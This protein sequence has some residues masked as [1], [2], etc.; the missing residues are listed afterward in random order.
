MHAFGTSPVRFADSVKSCVK[1]GVYRV[2]NPW[3]V[4]LPLM[5]RSR[6]R[7]NPSRP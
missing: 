3:N 6:T 1:R 4:G 5:H 2:L 7:R